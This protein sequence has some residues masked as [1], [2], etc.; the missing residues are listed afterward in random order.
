MT[1]SAME[2]F[3]SLGGFDEPRRRY[4]R[5]LRHKAVCSR[6]CFHFVAD[7]GIAVHQPTDAL[8]S[9]GRLEPLL[10][11]YGLHPGIQ[12]RAVFGVEIERGD[13]DDR[14]VPPAR[15][16]LQRCN[17]R[18]AVHLG[19]HQIEQDHVRLALL[20]TFERLATVLSLSYRPLWTLEPSQHPLALNRVV[21]HY[22][23]ARGRHLCPKP[24]DQPMQPLAVDWLG[25]IAGSAKR[26]APAVLIHDRD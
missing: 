1:R 3:Y 13:D 14:D 26:D 12:S 15:L 21:L 2:T 19:H 17:D 18:K 10:D 16:L 4:R 20:Y 11:Q 7:R 25:E 8:H 9:L 23:D 22:Q 5:C 6:C 24:A